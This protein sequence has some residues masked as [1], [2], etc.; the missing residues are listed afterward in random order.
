MRR[1]TR[2]LVYASILGLLSLWVFV[3]SL[4][5]TAI[6]RIW[7][8]ALWSAFNT[9]FL[10]GTTSSPSSFIPT[11]T[12]LSVSLVTVLPRVAVFALRTFSFVRRRRKAALRRARAR[13]A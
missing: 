4:G 2:T 10:A 5:L 6:L 9:T 11:L 13:A 7:L 12:V 8:G 3:P 1:T